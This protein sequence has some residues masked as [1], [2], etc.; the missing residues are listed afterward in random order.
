MNSCDIYICIYIYVYI[1]IC[2]YIY[3]CDCVC[4]YLYIYIYTFIYIYIY[5][6]ALLFALSDRSLI[7]LSEQTNV[8]TFPN[9]LAS[10]TRLG[11]VLDASWSQGSLTSAFDRF[12]KAH[13]HMKVS[14]AG[15]CNLDAATDLLPFGKEEWH[16][17]EGHQPGVANQQA[18]I[19]HITY[20]SI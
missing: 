3:I 11:R 16:V 6:I 9:F 1:Y 10:W 19:T 12:D 8:P 5:L 13:D 17:A 7:R 4:I 20:S 14:V 2:I 18:S 15:H